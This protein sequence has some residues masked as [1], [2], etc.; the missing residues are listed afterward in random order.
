MAEVARRR[1]G[2][3]VEFAQATLRTVRA[4]D[5]NAV[6]AHPGTQMARLVRRGLL[7]KV[8]VGYYIAV[9]QDRVDT[10]W[11][12]TLEAA[13]AGIATAAV[14]A[15]RPVLMGV[16]AARLHHAV[17]R[18]MA[19]AF[20]AVPTWRRPI[21]LQ[22]RDAIVRFVERDTDTLDAELMTTELG[23][24]LATTPEQTVLDLAHRPALGQVADE[25]CT[26][27]RALLPRCDDETFERIVKGQSLKAALARVRHA[28]KSMQ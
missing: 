4:R 8:A 11:R 13:A 22:D 2:L 25:A 6:Y 19:V 27:I 1:A 17:Y 10:D 20:V 28:Q 21:K 3:P 9:P 23:Q 18:A 7:H 26:A 14:G 15:G 16:S 5:A 12:P 24:C